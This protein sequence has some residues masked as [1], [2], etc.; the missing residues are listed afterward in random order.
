MDSDLLK[1][2]VFDLITSGR[3]TDGLTK[4]FATMKHNADLLPKICEKLELILGYFYKYRELVCDVQG[5]R[6]HGVDIVLKYEQDEGARKV[7]FQVKSF[8]DIKAVDWQT[9]LKAQM[10]EAETYHGSNMDDFYI[11]F[12]SDIE[13]H[14]DKIRNAMADLTANTKFICHPISP[15]KVLHFLKLGDAEIGAYIKRRLSKHDRVFADAVESMDRCSLLEGALVIHGLIDLLFSDANL[16]PGKLCDFSIA[17]TIAETYPNQ[18][19]ESIEEAV[20]RVIEKGFFD[21]E[22]YTGELTLN[23]QAT[24]ALAAIAYDAKV[25]YEYDD[26]DLKSYLFHSL[27]A[28][29]IEEIME[30]G[31]DF[32]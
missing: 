2:I 22:T 5:V 23:D 8:D 25:R 27:M 18:S 13:Q 14:R 4:Q 9:K 32:E 17:H 7:G 30:N 16:T 12:C 26:S 21:H 6:D 1:G 29:Q 28:D 15:P 11:L 31:S 3:T 19:I 20:M 24:N 10:F